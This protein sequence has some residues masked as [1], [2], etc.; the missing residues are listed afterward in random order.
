MNL[1]E[2]NYKVHIDTG[3]SNIDSNIILCIYGDED[4]TKSL[5]LRTTKN[6]RLEF[7]LKAIDVG[8]VS[9]S[10]ILTKEFDLN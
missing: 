2:I 1:I 10:L 7:D 9:Y 8:K 4:T 6:S 5:A 3:E